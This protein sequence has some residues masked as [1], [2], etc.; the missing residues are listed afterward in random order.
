MTDAFSKE[1]AIALAD[2]TRVTLRPLRHEDRADVA[3]ALATLSE[4]TAMRRFFRAHVDPSEE[5]LT[6]L[7]DVDQVDH[8]AIVATTPSPDLKQEHLIGVA[9]FVRSKDD[10]SRAEAAITVLDE[11][12]R[13]GIGRVLLDAL[14]AAATDAGVTRFRADVLKE[15]DAMMS[16]LAQVGA[17]K[18][19]EAD[20]CATFDVELNRPT[21]AG[22]GDE[23]RG[24]YAFLKII[25]RL[26]RGARTRS[27]P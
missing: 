4:K 21:E 23:E 17:T 27:R 7:T 19:A 11:H 1:R 9:R 10:P 6:Y 8:V 2:G 12:Q 15:N 3:H 22:D 26:A 13:R 5:V 14:V 24:P 16:I 20:G 18:V 25:A